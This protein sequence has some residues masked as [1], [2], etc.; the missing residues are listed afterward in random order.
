MLKESLSLKQR[1]FG[2]LPRIEETVIN[3]TES[4]IIG[5]FTLEEILESLA[6]QDKQD[7]VIFKEV[8]SERIN[9]AQL[10]STLLFIEEPDKKKPKFVLYQIFENSYYVYSR[11][12]RDYIKENSSSKKVHEEESSYGLFAPT[13]VVVRRVP[14]NILGNGVLGRAFIHSNYIEILDS[15]MGNE[16]Q[17]VL[18]H[19]VLHIMYPEK[20][21]ME[22]RQITRNYI[23]NTIYH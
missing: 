11:S 16:Y 1:I 13:G 21:E 8:F 20:R 18:T 19:E 17:E 12:K 14:Q 22:I 10:D 4:E 2:V 5:N 6:R 15:L 9:H 23:G 3:N 7:F